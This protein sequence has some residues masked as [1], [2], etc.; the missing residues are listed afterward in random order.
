MSLWSYANPVKFMNLSTKLLPF[1]SILAAI[2][3][4]IGL[5]W[6][7]LFTPL[8]Y[9]QGSTVKIIFL[10]VPT[11]M[12]AINIWF[13]M[14]VGSLIWL[15]RRH[16]VSA[17]VAR[18][19][20]PIGVMMTIMAMASGAIW[21]QPIWGTYWVWD[22]RLTSFM[23]LLVFYI[24]Y[25][26][27][28]GAIENQDRAAD[29]TSILC[30]VGTVYALLSRYSVNFWDQGLHQGATLSL[31]AERHIDNS[32]YHPLLVAIV[33]MMALVVALILVRTRMFI[34]LRAIDAL[35]RKRDHV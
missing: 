10:H 35:H 29:L 7:L 1:I 31:D 33:G 6:G 32:Y 9:K 23:I 34:R 8:D 27:L 22:P 15:I 25:I 19:A 13:I 18:A 14:L 5:I 4:I 24:G 17:L 11:A 12:M 16:H 3:L 26:A 28:W 21:G 30:M 2:G 20:A